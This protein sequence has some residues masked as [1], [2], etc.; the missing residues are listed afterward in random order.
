[1]TRASSAMSLTR[2]DWV[3]GACVFLLCFLIRP[4]WLIDKRMAVRIA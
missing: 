4:Q 1:M 2:D 3:F